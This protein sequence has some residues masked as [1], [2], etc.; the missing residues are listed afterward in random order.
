MQPLVQ[1]LSEGFDK[2]QQSQ[3]SQKVEKAINRRE[4]GYD[5][6]KILKLLLA[7]LTQNQGVQARRRDFR[8]N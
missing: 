7:R 8:Y 5:H 2:S 4:Y 6:G 3:T 1:I